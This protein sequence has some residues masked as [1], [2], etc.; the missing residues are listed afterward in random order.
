MK[1]LSKTNRYYLVFHALFSLI[2]I[3]V[4][5]YA[6][7]HMVYDDIDKKLKYESERINLYVQQ[8]DRLPG[9]NY[10]YEITPLDSLF[11]DTAIFKDTLIYEIYDRELIPY[12]E[13]EFTTAGNSARYKI[14]LRNILLDTDDLF[15]GLFVTTSIIFLLMITGLFFVNRQISRKIWAPFFK[16]L[17]RLGSYKL[18]EKKPIRLVASDINEFNKL[19][20]M[21]LSLMDQ[22]E[23]DYQNLREFNENVSHEIQTPA[24]V[25]SNKMELL[26]ESPKLSGV[27]FE[28]IQAAYREVNKL[29]RIV[30]SLALISRIDN[31][32]FTRVENVDVRRIVEA[33]LEFMEEMVRFKNIRLE[34][35]FDGSVTKKLDPALAN[36]L[37]ANLIRNAVQHNKQDGYIRI[38]LDEEKFEIENSGEPLQTDT[39]ELFLRFRKDNNTSPSMG[40]GLAIAGK[41]SKLYGFRLDYRHRRGVH[42]FRLFFKDEMD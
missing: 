18:E 2:T 31:Q 7:Q 21:I 10:I 19:N 15:I 33:T 29:S 40:L 6:I 41:I 12:R 4:F 39:Q 37:F 30:K 32:E 23:R 13:Y 17:A 27:E 8:N 1:L 11:P 24:A 35:T 26:M 3:A 14:T 38:F 34:T 36:V 16:S 20:D 25:I 28:A 22:I 9:S 5:Y 42:I